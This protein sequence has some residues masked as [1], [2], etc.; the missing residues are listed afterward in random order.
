MFNKTNKSFHWVLSLANVFATLLIGIF[1]MVQRGKKHFSTDVPI[2]NSLNSCHIV[3]A[4]ISGFC[5]T[6]S[7][8]STF[9]NE[10]YKLSFINMLIYY[11][12]S[13]AISYCLLVITPGSYAWTRGL[14]NPIC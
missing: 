8:I 4:L 11:T 9:I 7:T 13:I 10:G 5:G 6:L 2:V 14:T 3:S 1:T 12:V